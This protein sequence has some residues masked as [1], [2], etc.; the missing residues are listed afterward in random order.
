MS[1]RGYYT[2]SFKLYL[3]FLSCGILA[4]HR[5]SSDYNVKAGRW[6]ERVRSISVY[7]IEGFLLSLK[8]TEQIKNQVYKEG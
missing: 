3:I 8:S 4:L 1:Y 6:V 5:R 7:Y 2:A